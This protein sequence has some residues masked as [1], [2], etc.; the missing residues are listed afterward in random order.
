MLIFPSE[1]YVVKTNIHESAMISIIHIIA[2]THSLPFSSIKKLCTKNLNL[3]ICFRFWIIQFTIQ[4]MVFILCSK[5]SVG[6][7]SQKAF[8]NKIVQYKTCQN[9]IQFCKPEC[10]KTFKRYSQTNKWNVMLHSLLI[11]IYQTYS[12]CVIICHWT[13]RQMSRN[14]DNVKSE[15]IKTVYHL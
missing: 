7:K 12:R 3:L 9:I 4:G 1:C 8:R 15:E 11:W 2:S 14:N 5:Q 6:W 13:V 10:W